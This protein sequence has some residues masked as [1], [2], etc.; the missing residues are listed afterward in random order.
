MKRKS[1]RNAEIEKLFRE[2]YSLLEIGKK[3]GISRERSRQIVK[4]RERDRRELRRLLR[5]KEEEAF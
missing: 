2:G 1:K 5:L 3:F 4:E